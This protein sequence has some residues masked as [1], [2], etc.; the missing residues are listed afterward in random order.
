M[1]EKMR[2][3]MG[4]ILTFI[5]LTPLFVFAQEVA[6]EVVAAAVEVVPAAPAVVVAQTEVDLGSIFKGVI[7]MF[8]TWKEMGWQAGLAALM[9]VLLSTLKNSL[10]RAWLWDK[11]PASVKVF[12]APILG[13]FIFALGMGQ[14][15]AKIFWA[16][17]T[18]G[19]AS[20]YLHQVFEALKQA[21][22]IGE[23]FKGVIAWIASLLKKPESKA[24]NE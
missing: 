1:K 9:T 11:I 4:A 7:S 10:L 2:L 21:P 16:G 18:T 22:W 3:I 19:V 20:V 23:K 15:D 12:V 6:K 13:I 17:L 5:V 14:F 8:Q 24:V